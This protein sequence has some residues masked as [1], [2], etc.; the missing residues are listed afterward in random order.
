MPE[1][2]QIE[3]QQVSAPGS[4]VS[5]GQTPSGQSTTE[6]PPAD[7]QDES[8]QSSPE[9]QAE[10]EAAH[11][12]QFPDTPPSQQMDV[13]EMGV[14]W[15]NRAMESQR[16]LDKISEQYNT[17][18]EKIDSNTGQK[19]E[20][21]S[22]EELEEFSATTDNPAH[23]KWAQGEIR[24]LHKEELANVVRS[25][26][27]KTKAVEQAE[28]TKVDALQ[29]TMARYPNAFRKDANGNFIGWDPNSPLAQRIGYHMQDPEIANNPR[30]LVVAAALAYSDIGQ[31]QVA[32]SRATA[33]KLKSD[34]KSLEKKTLTEGAGVNSPPKPKTPLDNAKAKLQES[35]TVKDGAAAFKQV[36]KQRG[37][38]S[39]D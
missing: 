15:K 12:T 14:P 25:E 5:P 33:A 26:I 11:Q 36:L 18:L 23:R 20:K 31:G 27:G 13:D 38:I 37:R 34:V 4:E 21:Y 35:G 9:P 1:E 6:T 2:T 7:V 3:E 22:I 28:R 16:K 19:E 30:G 24:R 8:V 29:A 39:E 17:I 32:Q 10:A